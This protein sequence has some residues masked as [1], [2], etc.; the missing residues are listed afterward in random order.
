MLGG[1]LCS[2]GIFVQR[3]DCIH[4][5]DPINTA[6]RWQQMVRRRPYSVPGP[7][8]LWHING[9]HKLIRWRFVFH[10]AIDGI[11][12]L[13]LFQLTILLSLSWITSLVLFN[14]MAA[15]GPYE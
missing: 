11:S 4:H 10:G 14:S 7:N 5:T 13:V 1:M 2:Q 12:R 8:S 15:A 3:G 9:N 6:L